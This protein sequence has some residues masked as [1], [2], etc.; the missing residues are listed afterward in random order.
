MLKKLI[1]NEFTYLQSICKV[2]SYDII[3]CYS[4][5]IVFYINCFMNNL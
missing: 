4:E 2:P 3:N 5:T 1:R